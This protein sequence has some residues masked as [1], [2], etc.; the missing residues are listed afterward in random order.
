MSDPNDV[1]AEID[2]LRSEVE[3][4]AAELTDMR[5]HASLLESLA[6]E[7]PLTGLLNRR[8]FFRDLARA[9]AYRAR[10]GT[11]IALLVVDLDDFKPIND[12]YGHEAGDKALVHVA[13]LIRNNVRAS[14]SVGRLGGDEFAVILWQVEEGN[15]RM[16]A[17]SLEGMIEASPVNL[18]ALKMRLGASIGATMVDGKDT[19]EDALTRADH[20]MY[21]R[22]AE[23]RASQA[24]MSGVS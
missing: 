19:A 9:V 2:S 4:L 23:R 17:A 3:R 1:R 7:D 12:Q 20:G 15:A 21:A 10:Y 14:D 24:M 6:Q 13:T 5:A 16:K 8:G 22:K 18:G 11:P